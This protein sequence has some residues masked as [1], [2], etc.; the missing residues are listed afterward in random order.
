MPLFNKTYINIFITTKLGILTG[1]A[2]S[3]KQ[4]KHF[5]ADCECCFRI[6]I[7]K[8]QG[9]TIAEIAVIILRARSFGINPE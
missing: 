2:S 5:L 3:P 8:R 7:C 4:R 6:R 1:A 9:M